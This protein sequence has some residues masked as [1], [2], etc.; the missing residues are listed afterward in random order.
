MVKDHS[1]RKNGNPLLPLFGL[2]FSIRSNGS[3]IL[4]EQ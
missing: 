2:L 3:V 1:D 4:T